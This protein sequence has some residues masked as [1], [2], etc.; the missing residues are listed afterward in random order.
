MV[1]EFNDWCFDPARKT[2]DTGIVYNE[3]SYT[4]Y[5]V[6]YFVGQDAPAWQVA[7]ENHKASED[8]NAWTESL[9]EQANTQE[10]DGMKDVG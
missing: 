8:Y 6:M 4:G 5:H 7:V 9:I 3:G 10:L 2:G 1:T